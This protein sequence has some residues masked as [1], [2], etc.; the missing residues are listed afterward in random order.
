[1]DWLR[2]HAPEDCYRDAYTAIRDAFT[3]EH[4]MLRL[5]ESA[6]RWSDDDEWTRA[7]SMAAEAERMRDQATSVY[8]IDAEKCALVR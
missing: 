5:T 4:E 3:K 1:M 8:L 6:L 2:S 7:Q